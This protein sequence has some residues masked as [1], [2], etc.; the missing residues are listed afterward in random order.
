[1]AHLQLYNGSSDL[2]DF[3]LHISHGWAFCCLFVCFGFPFL[4]SSSKL[5]EGSTQL[6]FLK[7]LQRN[8][9]LYE[10]E[11]LS[12]HQSECRHAPIA[13]DSS[14]A[15]FLAKPISSLRLVNL[16]EQLRNM[17]ALQIKLCWRSVT[18]FWI[19]FKTVASRK[20]LY[21]TLLWDKSSEQ[22][23]AV[24]WGLLGLH[25]A[26]CNWLFTTLLP[27]SKWSTCPLQSCYPWQSNGF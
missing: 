25:R 11:H 23:A 27:T 5:Q 18:K 14:W 6:S 19:K 15:A 13:W 12:H 8:S 10:H 24:P 3:T 4:C 9:G 22:E 1:M 21:L 2:A 17:A 16:S 26:A 7:E 20:L